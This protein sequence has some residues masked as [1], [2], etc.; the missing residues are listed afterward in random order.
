MQSRS[1]ISS[2]QEPLSI[3]VERLLG[4][5][6]LGMF[7][8]LSGREKKFQQSQFILVFTRLL[9]QDGLY[10]WKEWVTNEIMAG[11]CR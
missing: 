2:I 11:L 9:R 1:S 3:S 5:E 10:D 7:I 8:E 6:E 4:S